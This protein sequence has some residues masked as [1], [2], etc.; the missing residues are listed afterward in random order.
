[1]QFKHLANFR[2]FSSAIIIIAFLFFIS[3]DEVYSQCPSGQSGPYITRINLCP[4]GCEVLIHWCCFDGIGPTVLPEISILGVEWPIDPNLP[5]S[6]CSCLRFE[7]F[8]PYLYPVPLLPMNKVLDAIYTDNMG[9]FEDFNESLITDCPV[10][11]QQIVSS[12]GG[13]YKWSNGLDYIGYKRCS[14]SPESNCQQSFSVCWELIGGVYKLKTTTNGP[15]TP[16]F[17][18]IGDCHPLCRIFY[19]E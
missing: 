9:C 17:D 1:L 4:D 6:G 14:I 11:R 15:A 7:E 13:C 10:T 3:F 2:L 16:Q 19:T 8:G 18:C 12:A 5:G